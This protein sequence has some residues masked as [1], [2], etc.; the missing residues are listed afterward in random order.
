MRM[1]QMICQDEEKINTF[2]SE[3]ETGYLGLSIQDNPY[4]VPLNY[5][6]HEGCIYFHGASEGKKIDMIKEN[7]NA[8]FVVSENHGTI[9]NPIPAKTDT[10]YL[11][12]MLFG[13]VELVDDL[14]E[15]TT[16]MQYLL[17]KYVPGYYPTALSQNHVDR[18]RSSM[19]SKTTVFK[20]VVK[21]ITAKENVMVE[22]KKYYKGREMAMDI[23]K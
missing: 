13:H 22:E 3:V 21:T 16:A 4:I 5:V 6:W 12:V 1:K 9:A 14:T 2:L 17:N 8:T 10:A 7:S 23:K 18:Y 20:L 11:S 15:A 19:G